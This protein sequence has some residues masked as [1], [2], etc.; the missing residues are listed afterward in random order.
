[1][2]ALASSVEGFNGSALTSLGT[3]NT[4]AKMLM[5]LSWFSLLCPESLRFSKEHRPYKENPLVLPA[6]PCVCTSYLSLS[7]WW[8]IWEEVIWGRRFDFDPWLE[9]LLS[10]I[11]EEACRYTLY[12][13]EHVA[14]VPHISVDQHQTEG[15]KLGGHRTLKACSPKCHFCRLGPIF[16]KGITSWNSTASWKSVLQAHKPV[17]DIY[18]SNREPCRKTRQGCLLLPFYFGIIYFFFA[19]CSWGSILIF[20]GELRIFLLK[21]QFTKHLDV[22][23]QGLAKRN[24]LGDVIWLIV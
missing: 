13:Q 23:N 22:L 3:S 9:E 7:L 21:I 8:T 11:A 6:W 24:C 2:S 4:K 17:G 16:S 12:W 14:A 10:I 5:H 18:K 15:R 1:M 19:A 20:K